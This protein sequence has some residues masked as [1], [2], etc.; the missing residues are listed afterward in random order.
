[1]NIYHITEALPLRCDDTLKLN[2]LTFQKKYI[3]MVSCTSYLEMDWI[4]PNGLM[5][6]HY[7]RSHKSHCIKKA[8]LSQIIWSW[9]FLRKKICHL[10]SI[11]RTGHFLSFAF[12][13]KSVFLFNV[14]PCTYCTIFAPIWYKFNEPSNK[15]QHQVVIKTMF[16]L[17]N[18]CVFFSFFIHT[19]TQLTSFD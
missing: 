16:A 3:H 9:N 13:F 10:E 17:I 4:Y 19:Q 5:R 1:M 12:I 15:I 8:W 7:F 14:R 18:A 2:E 6:Y 11:N